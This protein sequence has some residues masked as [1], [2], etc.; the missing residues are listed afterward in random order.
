MGSDPPRQ[1]ALGSDRTN[2]PDAATRFL[3]AAAPP[4]HVFN[5]LAF[6]GWFVHELWPQR[7]VYIDG[8]LDVYPDGFLE[9]YRRMMR[10]GQGWDEAVAKYDIAFAVVDFVDDPARDI[11]LRARLRGD[12]DWV[13]VCFADNVLVYARRT[14]ANAELI[15]RFGCPFDPGLRT[16]GSLNDWLRSA[17]VADVNQAAAAI[18]RMLPFAPA[19]RTPRT[20]LG[21]LLQRVAE[22]ELMNGRRVD[23]IAHLERAISLDPDLPLAQMRLGILRAQD[24]DLAAARRHFEAAQKLDPTNQSLQR[25]LQMLESLETRRPPTSAPAPRP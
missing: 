13:V 21:S 16:P 18:E 15:E 2:L 14:A 25:N 11:G 20:V 22:L 7:P 6:G 4:G 1:I 24:G 17:S 23:A 3:Q 5:I 9:A 19:A 12:G 8:R 10:T